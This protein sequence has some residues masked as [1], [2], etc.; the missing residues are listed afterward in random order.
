MACCVIFYSE[1]WY[2]ECVL[3]WCGT[4]RKWKSPRYS[5]QHMSASGRYYPPHVCSR[6]NVFVRRLLLLLLLVNIFVAIISKKKKRKKTKLDFSNERLTA[7]TAAAPHPDDVSPGTDLGKRQSN[8]SLFF[9]FFVCYTHTQRPP[10]KKRTWPG[11]VW[12][13][14]R[15][16]LYRLQSSRFVDLR[17]ADVKQKKGKITLEG[18]GG[19][20]LYI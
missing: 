14:I 18:G 3:G 2:I 16:S 10:N 12:H 7:A 13:F 1:E 4:S 5:A 8:S 20:T 15:D 11:D 6:R 19:T 9:F 17:E